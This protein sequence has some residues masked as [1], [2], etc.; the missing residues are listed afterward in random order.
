M[1]K[2]E[3]LKQKNAHVDRDKVAEFTDSNINHQP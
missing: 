2:Q 1:I 3:K